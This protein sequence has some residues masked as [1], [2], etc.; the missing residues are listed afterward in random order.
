MIL[1]KESQAEAAAIEVLRYPSRS[2]TLLLVV[3]VIF[4]NAVGNLVLTLGLKQVPEHL[5]MNPLGYIE[6]MVHPA[7]AAG[8]ALLIMWLLTRMALMSWADLSFV[9]PV[10]AAG[11]VLATVLG[12]LFLNETVSPERWAG[13]LLIFAGASLVGLSASHETVQNPALDQECGK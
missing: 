6:A 11:Y 5:G 10:T 4:F 12:H 9:L 3:S 7:V 2:R 1:P 13:T 8:I